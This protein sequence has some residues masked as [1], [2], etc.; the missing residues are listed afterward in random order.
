MDDHAETTTGVEFEV[1]RDD[2]RQCRT[3]SG[4]LPPDLRPGQVLFRIDRFA[5]TSNNI[6]YALAGDM[7]GY[8][9]FFPAED[10]WGRLP[11]MGF[12]DVLRSAHGEVR[13]GERVF[14]FFPMSTHLVIEAV[15]ASP[16]Q[17]MDGA[18]HRQDSAPVYRQY[19]R[20][21]GDPLYEQRR[22]DALLLLRGLF[23]TSFLVDDFLADNDG[24][25]AATFVL[26]SASSKTAIALAYLLSQRRAGTVVGLTSPR[27]R[28]FV[29]GLGC[30]DRVVSYDEIEAVDSG[31]PTVFVDHAGDGPVVAAVHAHFGDQL[32]HSAVVGAT[33]WDRRRTPA[34]LPGPVPSFFFA[35]SQFEKRQAEWGPAEFQERLGGAWQRFLAFSDGWL[36]VVRGHGLAEVERVY[37]E[38]LEGR[39]QPHQGHVLSLWDAGAAKTGSVG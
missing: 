19:L 13:A 14:G 2:W 20:C 38:V 36:E 32:R 29:E 15:A 26:S 39:A 16:T 7:L 5:L 18:S 33:H 17:F 24:F 11:V 21:A 23:F 6:S 3:T 31:R 37:R 8:W 22:E 30:Y 25:G 27:N 9:R 35:P 10:P 12:A 34:A 28:A 4:P 1:R